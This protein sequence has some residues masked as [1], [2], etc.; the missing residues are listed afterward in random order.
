VPAASK[1][2]EPASLSRGLENKNFET[3]NAQAIKKK[4]RPYYYMYNRDKSILYYSSQ[5]LTDY[6]LLGL[7]FFTL[8]NHLKNRTHYLGKYSF[9]KKFINSAKLLNMPFSDV[10]AMFKKDRFNLFF[11]NKKK[12][13]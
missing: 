7:H 2:Q 8:K 10:E 4:K 1:E 12:I 6:N 9:S 5:N 3:F 13:K 11:N